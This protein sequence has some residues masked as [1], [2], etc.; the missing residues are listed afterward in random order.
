MFIVGLLRSA[1]RPAGF[2]WP[3]PNRRPSLP[4]A[5]FLCGG[6]GVLRDTPKIGTMAHAKYL[7]GLRAIQHNVGSPRTT[8]YSLDLWAGGSRQ[9]QKAARMTNRVPCLAR[10]WPNRAPFI[11]SANRLLTAEEMLSLQGLPTLHRAAARRA[12]ISD[13]S[14]G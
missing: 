12:G 14:L 8:D 5:R 2:G 6:A 7:L 9:G 13:W 10:T 3:T 11:T 4:L 1:G